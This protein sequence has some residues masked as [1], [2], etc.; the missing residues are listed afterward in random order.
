MGKKTY[1]TL[2]NWSFLTHKRVFQETSV[3]SR[4]GIIYNPT[5]KINEENTIISRGILAAFLTQKNSLLRSFLWKLAKEE[6]AT[7]IYSGDKI[8]TFLIEVSNY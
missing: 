1:S 5:S 3:L 7:A 2:K 6:T 8:K 4:L